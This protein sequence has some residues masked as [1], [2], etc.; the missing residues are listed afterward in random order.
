M[1][2]LENIAVYL[3]YRIVKFLPLNIECNEIRISA[4]SPVQ[5]MRGSE[6]FYLNKHGDLSKWMTDCPIVTENEAEYTF[7]KLKSCTRYEQSENAVNGF[8]M[9]DNGIRVG[10]AGHRVMGKDNRPKITE[11]RTLVFRFFEAHKDCSQ[12]IYEVIKKEERLPSVLIVSKPYMGK[13][14]MLRDLTQKLSFDRYKCCVIDTTLELSMSGINLGANTAILK[15]YEKLD[16][17]VCAIKNLSPDV[18]V[19]DEVTSAQDVAS[20]EYISSMGVPVIA[21]CHSADEKQL[22]LRE[23]MKKCICKGMFDYVVF[24]GETPG[25]IER[26]VSSGE[27]CS[28][29]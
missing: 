15:G 18:L 10:I 5:V 13:T 11:V 19:F 17:A 1:M 26:I 27:I 2:T 12:D 22:L 29:I 9:L 20:L 6:L 28:N 8:I 25:K 3:P 7:E 24:L 21:T 23:D 4:L 14:T 16:G